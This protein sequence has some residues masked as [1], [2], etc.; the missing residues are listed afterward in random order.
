M[1]TIMV[2]RVGM[3]AVV[4]ITTRSDRSRGRKILGIKGRGETGKMWTR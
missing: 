1:M 2:M 4:G 3:R